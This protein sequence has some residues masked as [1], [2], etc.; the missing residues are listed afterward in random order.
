MKK[1]LFGLLVLVNMFLCKTVKAESINYEKYNVGDLVEVNNER[2]YVVNQSDSSKEYVTLLKA[3]PLT[4][5]EVNIYGKVNTDEN[6]VNKYSY[7]SKGTALDIAGYGAMAYYT[8]ETCGYTDSS[9]KIEEN[10]TNNYQGSDIEFVI[11]NWAL[12][13]FLNNELMP[14]DNY[15]ARLLTYKELID[16]LGYDIN[17]TS[18]DEL[19]KNDNVPK[20]VYTIDGID[21]S[22]NAKY[23]LIAS[24]EDNEK[25]EYFIKVNTE[26]SIS[27]K[28]TG[29]EKYLV[30]PVI[31]ANKNS[32]TIIERSAAEEANNNDDVI[33]DSQKVKVEDTLLQK[34]LV[35]TIIGLVLIGL[36][37]TG[38]LIGLKISYKKY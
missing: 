18:V 29:D 10:C 9:V 22:M 23:S 32:V 37:I 26:G 14:V 4:T 20:W 19:I 6:R 12:D 16:N 1:I 38:Y 8:S 28:K 15:S 25:I 5:E 17:I 11:N 30:R 31:N 24:V 35:G 7:E 13:K 2:Y 3:K 33:T 34:S 36:G 21:N 27:S